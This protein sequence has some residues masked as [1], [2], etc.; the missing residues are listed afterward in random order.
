MPRVN[1]RHA[2]GHS[3]HQCVVSLD[4]SPGHPAADAE[5]G[6][7]AGGGFGI[8]AQLADAADGGLRV[9]PAGR[10]LNASLA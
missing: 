9:Q 3:R 8:V 1:R 7:D 5:L 2:P 10:A 4:S 6:E